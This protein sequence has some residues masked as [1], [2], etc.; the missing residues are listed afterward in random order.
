MKSL[1]QLEFWLI[2]EIYNF[3]INN[4]NEYT[5]IWSKGYLKGLKY[6]LEKIKNI[7]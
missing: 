3:K 6:V 5:R 1:K 4:H 2:S 7:K